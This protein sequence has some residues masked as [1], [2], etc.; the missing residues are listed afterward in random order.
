MCYISVCVSK[1]KFCFC[2]SVCNMFVYRALVL[3]V[4]HHVCCCDCLRLKKSAKASSD[5]EYPGYG[6]MDYKGAATENKSTADRRLAQSA[7][8][9]HYQHQKQQML[10][11]EK[12]V[13]SSFD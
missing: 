12:L 9:Y 6:S 8:M 3:W 5:F 1:P 11:M 7:Q 4:C 10:E 2:Q 13:L